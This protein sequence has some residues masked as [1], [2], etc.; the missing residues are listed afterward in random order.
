M[1]ATYEQNQL[2]LRAGF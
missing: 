2:T 1:K